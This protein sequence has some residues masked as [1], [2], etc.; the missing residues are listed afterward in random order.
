MDTDGGRDRILY[1]DAFNG[2]SGD[3]ILGGLLDLGLPLE[4]LRRRLASLRRF[5]ASLSARLPSASTS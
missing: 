3:M 4:H 5:S 1:F 2:V